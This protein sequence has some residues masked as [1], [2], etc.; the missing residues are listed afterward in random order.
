MRVRARV[1]VRTECGNANKTVTYNSHIRSDQ[2]RNEWLISQKSTVSNRG[3]DFNSLSLL[4]LI[5]T[6]SMVSP[7]EDLSL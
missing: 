2:Q 7:C 5:K 6:N 1:R 4:I 3:S